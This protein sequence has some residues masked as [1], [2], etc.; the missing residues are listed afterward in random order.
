MSVREQAAPA[1]DAI[2][3]RFV[4]LRARLADDIDLAR[5][6]PDQAVTLE[7]LANR[8]RCSVDEVRPVVAELAGMSLL[9]V[10]GETCVIAPIRR[11][12]LL[13]QL[14]RRLMLEQQVAEAAARHGASGDRAAIKELARMLRRSALVGDLD[15]YMAADRRLERAIATAADLPDV[16]EQLFA[17]KREFRRAWCAHNRLR[18]LNVPAGLRQALVDAVLAQR[19]E[20]AKEAV[21]NFI[22]YLRKSY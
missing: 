7:Q 13:P 5:L 2:M 15:G 21:R 22:E 14:D 17:L 8:L 1:G 6:A 19:P 20:D 9:V 18:D 12:H 10:K 4:N 3:A 16:A 11:K